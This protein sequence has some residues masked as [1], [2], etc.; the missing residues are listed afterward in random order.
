[1]HD[2][3][4]G[5]T[6]HAEVGARL[7]TDWGFPG[8]ADI[9]L[10]HMDITVDETLPVTQGEIVYLA[11]KLVSGDRRVDLAERFRRKMRLYE[12]DS[13]AVAAIQHRL[14]NAQRIQ[15][16]IERATGRSLK[17]ILDSGY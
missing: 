4:R 5:K 2:A 9:V 12:K 17:R 7:I 10:T 8:L 14:D 15:K 6:S 11:D 13:R 1:V 16:K 3:G